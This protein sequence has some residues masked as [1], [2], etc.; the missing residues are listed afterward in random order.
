M[1]RLPQRGLSSQSLK[2][3]QLNQNKQK[4]E[5]IPTKTNNT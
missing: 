3:Q 5:N 1:V 4:T 2:Y